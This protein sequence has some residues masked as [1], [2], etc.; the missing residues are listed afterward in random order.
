MTGPTLET[1][2]E[3]W[4][5]ARTALLRAHHALGLSA[6]E[7]A[8]LLGC[9]SRNAVISKRYRLGLFAWRERPTGAGATTVS[10]RT[11]TRSRALFSQPPFLPVEPLPDM[12]LPLPPGA[13]P[14]PLTQ[15]G[16]GQCAWP[17]GPAE[18]PGDFRTLFCCAPV[19]GEQSYCPCHRRLASR[20]G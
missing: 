9:V 4:S 7:S 13:D 2:S 3:G 16:F 1:T 18:Q 6:A 10:D 8:R 17:L 5:E 19:D 11:R 15:K 12:D 14:R 20:R